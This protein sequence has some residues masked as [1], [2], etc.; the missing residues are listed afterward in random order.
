MG[1]TALL[2]GSTAVASGAGIVPATAAPNGALQIVKKVDG[3]DAHR[4]LTPGQS[5]TYRVEFSAE[6]YDVDGAAA[7]N[8]AVKLVDT[9]PAEF[10]GWAISGVNV[11][12]AGHNSAVSVNVPGVSPSD[13]GTIG[14]DDAD[15]S[16]TVDIKAPTDD[17]LTGLPTGAQGWLEYVIT[18]PDTLSPRWDGNS[19]DLVNTAEISGLG[20]TT[21][22]VISKNDTAVISV[23][24]PLTVDV[25]PAKAWDPAS[26]GFEPG[27]ASTITIGATQASNVEAAS[28]VLQD[29][30]GAADGATA[31]DAENPFRYVDFA[32]FTTDP[33]TQANWPTGATAVS[34]EVYAFVGGTW[35][36]TTY[37]SSIDNADIAG[38]RLGYTGDIEP[39]AVAT[40]PF[41]VTQREEDR[42][43]TVDLSKGYDA[44]NKVSATVTVPGEA[45]VTKQADA[46]FAVTPLTIAVEAGK[47]FIDKTGTEVDPLTTVAGNTVEVLLTAKNQDSPQ[48]ATL[49]MLTIAEPGV[50]ADAEYFSDALQFAGFDPAFT[51]VW[52]EGAKRATLTWKY[53]DG[54]TQGVPLN[55]PGAA[56]PAA[57]P[58]GHTNEDVVGFWINFTG[59]IVPGAVSQ[60]KYKINTSENLATNAAEAGPFTNVIDVMGTR[61]GITEPATDSDSADLK[62]VSPKIEV[63]T[64]KKISPSIVLPG[65]DVIVQLPTTATATGDKT[66][67]TEIVVTDEL[68]GDGTNGDDTFWDA[69]NVTHVLA[70]IEVPTGGTLKI[71]RFDSGT[72]AWEPVST[73]T[74]TQTSG[75]IP[76]PG[77]TGTTGIR[78][79]Y[80]NAAGFGETTLVKPNLKF[81]A[82]T[83]LR[84]GGTTTPNDTAPF[85]PTPY[86]NTVTA[87][88]EGILDTRPV[89]DDA[90]ATENVNLRAPEWDGPGHG[91]YAT[92]K[93]TDSH[94]V[95]QSDA[96]TSTVHT[97]HV[98]KTGYTKVLFTDPLSPTA[99]VDSSV[100]DAFNLTGVKP[101]TLADDPQLAWDI[102]S[103]VELYD[104]LSWVA[105]TNAPADGNW[106]NATG[107][108][109]VTLTAAEQQSTLGMR[110]SY[111]PND[112]ARQTAIDAGDIGVPAAGSGISASGADRS[113]ELTWQLRDKARS[114]DW[115][116]SD[117]AFNCTTGTPALKQGCVLNSF[118]FR[119]YTSSGYT[120]GA[121]SD[122]I[123][124]IDGTPNVGLV[125][126][127][128]GL[129]ED[130]TVSLVVPKYGDVDPAFYPATWFTLTATNASGNDLL[131][132]NNAN[133]IMK[134]GK[135]R[136][137]DVASSSVGNSDMG[138][139]PFAGR[140]FDAEAASNDGNT[141]DEFNLTGLTFAAL[142]SYIDKSASTVELWLYNEGA[143]S[144]VSYSIADVEAGLVPAAEFAD[145]I[146]VS[147][148]YQSTDPEANGN[149]IVAGDQLTVRLDVQMRATH[150]AGE[151]AT[152][153][154]TP[155]TG[156]ESGAAIPVFNS[157]QAVGQ[158]SVIDPTDMPANNDDAEVL[159]TDASI[160]VLLEKQIA[161]R[162]GATT[163]IEAEAE[164]PV[165]VAIKA[166]PGASKV[167]LSELTIEDTTPA[168]WSTFELVSLPEPASKPTNSDQYRYDYY[169]DGA[170][171]AQSA[172]TGEL[173]DV[174]GVRITFDRVDGKY[175]PLGATSWTSSWG[176]AELPIEVKLR[177][178]ESIDWK[179]GVSVENVAKTTANGSPGMT[180]SA[181]APAELDFNEGTHKLTVQKRAPLDST[182]HQVEPLTSMPWQLIFT[183]NGT[184][185]LPLET[186]TDHL[187]ATLDWNG[188]QPTFS[189]TGGTGATID[190]E[191]IEVELSADS[192]SLQF[193]WPEGTRMDPG[194][195]ITIELGITLQPGL[196]A[197]QQAWNSVV[198]ETGVELASCTQPSNNG[199]Q[200]AHAP[201][202]GTTDCANANFV[203]P[204]TG[205]LVG[206]QKFVNGEYIDT[207]SENLVTGSMSTKK[208]EAADCVTPGAPDDY[209]RTECA[210]YTTVGATDNW[211]LQQ[212]NAG[213]TNLN[214]MTIVDLLPTPG[215][216]LLV[217]GPAPRN[218]TFRPVIDLDSLEFDELPAGAE[219]AIDVTT[220]AQACIG[221]GS[222]PS[223]WTADD[224]F[225]EDTTINPA[226]ADW[227]PLESFTGDAA[228]VAGFR[229][230]V[231]M[232]ATPLAPGKW[233]NMNYDTVNRVAGQAA[234]GLQ[235]TLAQFEQ[236]QFAWNQHGV[237]A[238]DTA[239]T[240]IN[241]V[242]APQPAGVTVKTG[243]LE[244][245]KTVA[246]N[247]VT[248][249]PEAFDVELACTVP[250]GL[251][252][253]ERVALD[254]GDEATLT[255][256]ADGTPVRV[257]GLPIG[258]NC[259][260]SE[261]GELGDH[262]EIARTF[263]VSDGVNPSVD[264]QTAQIEI[265]EPRAQGE[266][267]L[268]ALT[269][270]YGQGGLIVEKSVRSDNEYDLDEKTLA[271]SFDFELSCVAQGAK[272]P[273][274]RKFSLKTGEQYALSDLPQGAV[275]DLTEVA[276]GGA[277][278]VEITVAGTSST[279]NGGATDEAGATVTGVT[280]GASA[281]HVLVSNGFLGKK[282]A[283]QGTGNNGEGTTGQGA[284]G[285][286]VTGGDIT[287]MIAAA[288]VLLGLGAG[289]LMLTRRRKRAN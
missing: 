171:V 11:G 47:T 142:P 21:N 22:G 68:T 12:L 106:M 289:A 137:T 164:T 177:N 158:D 233:V 262:G 226:N 141:F 105:A 34:V 189:Q 212:V 278:S 219:T 32:G 120:V 239:G 175:F 183:N 144:T 202:L 5:V 232:T 167:P 170:W 37:A 204:R 241:L 280:V 246:A 27:A 195:T 84:S 286:G 181:N 187:P 36:W 234:G 199:Q 253:P 211:R 159:L 238:W 152:T 145:A 227:T 196:T 125:K 85:D 122:E 166:T 146:G 61:A 178:P 245:S 53:A 132:P 208:P 276:T 182:T 243:A 250:S 118:E 240:P 135:I 114:G 267:T 58:A 174:A 77:A 229:V 156:G 151:T 28:L 96:E 281:Q 104:G 275:C 38:V 201:T 83:E 210:D 285:L 149:A 261:S 30:P 69:H 6:N 64:E 197:S 130:V 111:A 230:M 107:F 112:T 272:Q 19:K 81:K 93:W 91:I 207:L 7:D 223:L 45:P 79:N 147:V 274:E 271:K 98:S 102:V 237:F 161:V 198:V 80:T 82:R 179:K 184:G 209:T 33:N 193:T 70:P 57:P 52:P 16:I 256:P 92:K 168:F 110:I 119:G 277:N 3:K 224:P 2:L 260:I 264:G 273:I 214:R 15:R 126:T 257:D 139:S 55:T 215:D 236:P 140:D 191:Q 188:A 29:H 26:Q 72:G 10:A 25:T 284:G 206:A 133:G 17:G 99:S 203:T 89:T 221:D 101:I 46:P 76:V 129:D 9:L 14:T 1:V 162:G 8:G 153:P 154:G 252:D 23:D 186:V 18:V 71:E 73:L 225:C 86:E 222:G 117:E 268:V 127:V 279:G 255:L 173:G 192:R 54:R 251:A 172:F 75:D 194:E 263:Q 180:V 283:D 136:V 65:D 95:T 88:A 213:T 282:P 200:S 90:S 228:D 217:Q 62:V 157:A 35:N 248:D 220:N 48:S 165:D 51:D 259:E 56:L 50:G 44:S 24:V 42:L 13:A 265:R 108:V 94:L 66:K 287:G 288:V 216:M 131:T 39:G 160:D 4:E 148:T 31:L 176:S 266:A 59:A 244:V 254:L 100:F 41:D 121:D 43:G 78:F 63:V 116:T 258:T 270:T 218:S 115:V 138:V 269:N 205:T 97:W 134:L 60:V 49:N 143:E 190:P 109:G 124:L 169:V 113:Y 20:G 242:K 123:S 155:I 150:R 185:Y 67:P 163:L 74:A 235:P 247:G 103:N 40:Q 128:G 249:T 231:D 87:E